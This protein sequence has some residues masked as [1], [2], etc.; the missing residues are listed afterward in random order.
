[1]TTYTNPKIAKDGQYTGRITAVWFNKTKTEPQ[2]E[3]VKITFS[4]D[5]EQSVDALFF[6]DKPVQEEIYRKLLDKVQPGLG[7]STNLYR[8]T[9]MLKDWAK[10]EQQSVTFTQKTNLF[11]GREY[12]NAYLDSVNSQGVQDT[13]PVYSLETDDDIPF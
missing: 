8:A 13:A 11:K 12:V 7:N 3:Y 6:L 10:N 1:M 5:D 2:R 4:L 9:M